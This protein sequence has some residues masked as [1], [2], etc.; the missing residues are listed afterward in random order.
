MRASA[1]FSIDG[2]TMLI[3]DEY[4]PT[5]TYSNSLCW[6]WGLNSNLNGSPARESMLY[7]P[8]KISRAVRALA[9]LIA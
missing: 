9:V 2:K 4:T 3:A 6:A 7:L 8:L 1:N 5:V